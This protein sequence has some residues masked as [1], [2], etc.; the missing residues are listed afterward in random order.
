MI[1]VYM[2]SPALLLTL[3]HFVQL[4]LTLF[5]LAQSCHNAIQI[6]EL[7]LLPL[8]YLHLQTI[9]LPKQRYLIPFLDWQIQQSVKTHFAFSI[10][11]STF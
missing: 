2:V 3:L 1:F 4:H 11:V 5:H 7:H 9:F 8:D 10:F 6:I